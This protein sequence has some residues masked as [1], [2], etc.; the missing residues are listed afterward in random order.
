MASYNSDIIYIF[1]LDSLSFIYS[2]QLIGE[3]TIAA[4]WHE[5]EDVLYISTCCN[6]KLYSLNVTNN[7][8][9]N[10][11]IGLSSTN[12]NVVYELRHFS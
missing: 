9:V 10:Y 4:D 6:P 5:T 1:S 2:Y 8:S 3:Q 12:A 7:F 11:L